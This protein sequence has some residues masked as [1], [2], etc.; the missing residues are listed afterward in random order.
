M[1]DHQLGSQLRRQLL[2][3]QERGQPVDGRRLQ[4]LLGDLCGDSQLALLPALKV[5]VMSAAFSSAA[6]QQPPLPSDPRLLLRLQQE[7]DQVF[8]QAIC[9]RMASVLRGLL[10]LPDAVSSV[11]NP[12]PAPT[13]PAP[14]A[15]VQSTTAIERYSTQPRQ[16][17]RSVVA[18]LG[19]MAG[20]LVVGVLAGLAWLM[21]QNRIPQQTA[22]QPAVVAPPARTADPEPPA[23]PEPPPAP[24]LQS[25]DLQAAISTVQQLYAAI[26]AGQFDAARQLFSPASA[27]QFDPSF[28]SQ[29]REVHVSDLRETGS[30]GTT[31]NL[32][33]V[34]TFTYP[35][36]TSQSES[37]SFSVDTS[38][39][40]ALITASSFGAVLKARS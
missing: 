11:A 8:T 5:L 26:S 16:T 27:D 28:F 35:D 36:G 12:S 19:F 29:F 24:D 4:A 33:G 38:S 21:Q 37:R 30:S 32:S 17:S 9:Q 10:A 25:A 40:P 34:V 1:N 13:A 15:E 22:N 23:P 2:A 7:L 3:D 18:L 20:V 14:A 6:G 39:Q 31:V